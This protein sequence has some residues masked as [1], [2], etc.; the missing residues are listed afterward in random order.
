MSETVARLRIE[1][2]HLE[3]QIWRRI[4]VPITTNLRALH[5]IVQAVMPWEDRHLYEFR[6]G[7]KVYGEP[8]PDDAM[9]GRKILQ[10]K[11]LR[12][13]A[14]VKRGLTSFTY[15]Y[16]FGDDWTH[17][18]TIENV[19][20]GDPDTDYPVFVDGARRAPPEDVGGTTGFEEFLEAVVDP[21]HEDHDRILEWCGG[22]F[23]PEDIDERRVRMILENFANRRRGPLMSHRFDGRKKPT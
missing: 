18:I 14:L 15:I 3:P 8:M 9:W 7:E 17:R 13:G 6:V 20:E 1:L 19:G 23:D 16:D 10:A 22:A 21:D 11:S 5:H 12:L 4:D 2:E